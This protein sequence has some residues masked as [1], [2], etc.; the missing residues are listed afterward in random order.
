MTLREL[1]KQNKKTVAE[2]AKVLNVT[3]RAVLNYEQGIRR[4]GLEEI[5][6]LAKVFDCTAEEIILAQL[7]SIEINNSK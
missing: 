3:D 2:I 6:A 4:I 5:L 7:K 1:R